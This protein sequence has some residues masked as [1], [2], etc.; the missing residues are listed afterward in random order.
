[1]WVD[2][3]EWLQEG[4]HGQGVWGSEERRSEEPAGPSFACPATIRG[5]T[6]A[7]AAVSAL[8]GGA[9]R[10]T[11]RIPTAAIGLGAAITTGRRRRNSRAAAAAAATQGQC[12]FYNYFWH[13]YYYY[14]CH[15]YTMHYPGIGMTRASI[16][17]RGALCLRYCQEFFLFH[18]VTAPATRAGIVL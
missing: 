12:K 8:G 3:K 14:H 9:I 6:I 2:G 7:T 1:M 5:V 16:T 10:G 13:Y 4:Y 18:V 11:R 17:S 15:R